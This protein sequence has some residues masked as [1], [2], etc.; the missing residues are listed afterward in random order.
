MDLFQRL[1]WMTYDWRV[2]LAARLSPKP[3][4]NLGFVFMDDDTVEQ[5]GNGLLGGQSYGLL[6]PRLIYGRL[7]RELSIQGAKAVAFDVLFAELRPDHPLIEMP[8]QKR[9][10]S[11]DFFAQQIKLSGNVILA[12]QNAVVPHELFRTNAWGIGDISS[13][14]DS[15][16]ISR[17]VKAFKDY[18]I[19]N[20]LFKHLARE[21]G[22]KLLLDRHRVTFLEPVTRQTNLTLEIDSNGFFRW[23][24]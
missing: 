24:T 7:V 19:W 22:L 23:K 2:R 17:R 1:E 4:T 9:L 18:H 14:A 16:G 15:D 10:A 11:D 13:E 5:L 8:D 3:T 6:W 12:A 20:P 21:R